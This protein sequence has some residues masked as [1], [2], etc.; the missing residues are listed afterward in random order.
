MLGSL[1]IILTDWVRVIFFGNVLKRRPFT[2]ILRSSQCRYALRVVDRIGSEGRLT[3]LSLNERWRC[4]IFLLIVSLVKFFEGT[5]VAV[6]PI[7]AEIADHTLFAF[8]H[9]VYLWVELVCQF[10]YCWPNIRTLIKVTHVVAFRWKVLG[11]LIVGREL[12]LA[13]VPPGLLVKAL[14]PKIVREIFD[15]GIVI[16]KCL[17]A[18]VVSLPILPSS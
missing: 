9:V 15:E 4:K 5:E 16:V 1:Q 13:G 8:I 3:L 11:L 10:L 14:L 7:S 2:A 6:E 12:H 18:L 17:L